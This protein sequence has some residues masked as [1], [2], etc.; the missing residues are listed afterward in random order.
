MDNELDVN[1]WINSTQEDL[2]IVSF[3]SQVPMLASTCY[4]CGLAVEKMLKAYL[5]AKESKLTKT[6]DLDVLIEK[7]EKHSPDF[8]KYRKI[9]E[10]ISVFSIVRYPPDRNLTEQK[11]RKTIEN[12]H[13]IVNFAMAKLKELGYDKTPQPTSDSMKKIMAA[14][15]QVQNITG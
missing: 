2:V 4:H 1:D 12:T 13:E 3:G 7:C 8:S 10:D 5:I 11:M 9:C 14:I 15:Q 6:H